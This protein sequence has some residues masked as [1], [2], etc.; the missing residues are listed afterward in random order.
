MVKF[1]YSQ[2][3]KKR[4]R[5][6][7]ICDTHDLLNCRCSVNA[8]KIPFHKRKQVA[9]D[10]LNSWQ[11]FH[12]GNFGEIKDE[13]LRNAAKDNSSFIFSKETQAIKEG[14]VEIKRV[15]GEEGDEADEVQ[16]EEV[17]EKDYRELRGGKEEAEVEEEVEETENGKEEEEAGDEESGKEE[18]FSDD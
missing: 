2:K 11:H 8:I 15:V 9:V 3:K 1:I 5:E 6:G 7:T 18:E 4:F 13:I 14:D 17:S 16:Q 12:D 10:D